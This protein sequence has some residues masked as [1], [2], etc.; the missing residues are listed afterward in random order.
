[1]EITESVIKYV[2]SDLKEQTL[3][4]QTLAPEELLSVSSG[5]IDHVLLLCSA[6]FF[7]IMGGGLVSALSSG[8][9]KR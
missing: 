6:F 3:S 9:V 5:Y 1:M 2:D 7:L 8:L 4:L